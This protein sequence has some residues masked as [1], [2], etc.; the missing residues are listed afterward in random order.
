MKCFVSCSEDRESLTSI[1]TLFRAF[2]V[3]RGQKSGEN[4]ATIRYF[5]EK[6]IDFEFVG[7]F[8]VKFAYS[9]TE[10]TDAFDHEIH[11]KTRKMM[12][13]QLH[14]EKLIPNSWNRSTVSF[15]LRQLRLTNS[16]LK[17]LNRRDTENAGDEPAL[18][19]E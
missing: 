9:R 3:F 11:E 2:R 10:I 15:W 16:F 6:N 18:G 19:S 5:I 12:H 7:S 8:I 1:G 14:E 17:N 13:L 4:L